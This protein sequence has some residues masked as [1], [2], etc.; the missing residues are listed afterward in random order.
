MEVV[1][2]VT[3]DDVVTVVVEHGVPKGLNRASS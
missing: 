1:D 2:E 3:V